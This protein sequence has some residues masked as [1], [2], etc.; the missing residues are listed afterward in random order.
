MPPFRHQFQIINV[1]TG[2]PVRK[3]FFSLDSVLHAL[4]RLQV[5]NPWMNGKGPDYKIVDKWGKPVP[6]SRVLWL[7]N[8]EEEVPA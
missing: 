7:E 3:N 2:I 4:L 1:D 8:L 5:D 6:A